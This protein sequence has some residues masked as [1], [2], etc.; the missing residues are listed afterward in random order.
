MILQSLSRLGASHR[1]QLI[2][3]YN[4][5][6]LTLTL[7]LTPK[8]EKAAK[9]SPVQVIGTI[10]EV[11]AELARPDFA[12]VIDK[13]V[14]SSSTLADLDKQI[15]EAKKV[16]QAALDEAKKP[17]AKKPVTHAAKPAAVVKKPITA[18]SK[19]PDASALKPAYQKAP[20]AATPAAIDELFKEF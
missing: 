17:A 7:I 9:L 2:P 3:E 15:E 16:K 20:A 14:V 19:P 1:I 13:V 4:G 10:E 18:L 6:T 11:E 8:D 5:A 12:A